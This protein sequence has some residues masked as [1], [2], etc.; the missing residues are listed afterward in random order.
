[1][2]STE[3][4][5]FFRAARVLQSYESFVDLCEFFELREFFRATRVLQSCE[6]FFP[7]KRGNILE[8]S[9]WKS[10]SFRLPEDV[11]FAMSRDFMD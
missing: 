7:G 4:V 3:D 6:S 1:M 8:F 2:S 5:K 9:E 10:D 11:V